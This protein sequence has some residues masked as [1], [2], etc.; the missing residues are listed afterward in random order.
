M[1]R[2]LLTA[3]IA[4]LVIGNTGTLGSSAF[5]AKLAVDLSGPASRDGT[6]TSTTF[7]LNGAAT[8]YVTTGSVSGSDYTVRA[9][10]AGLVAA[11]GSNTFSVSLAALLGDFIGVWVTSTSTGLQYQAGGGSM[12]YSTTHGT[13]PTPST[14]ITLST[15]GG[16]YSIVGSG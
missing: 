2:G 4:P 14:V 1:R 8:A 5:A 10:S 13:A 9:V 15:F 11:S 7:R 12:G 6:V 16:R 3:S